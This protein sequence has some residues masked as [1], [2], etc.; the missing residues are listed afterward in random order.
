MKSID[1][2][3]D[4][5]IGIVQYDCVPVENNIRGIRIRLNG[6]ELK[7][8]WKVTRYEHSKLGGR[9]LELT[10][11]TPSLK[12]EGFDNVASGVKI[13]RIK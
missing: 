3:G 11:D 5:R 1:S 7:A 8:G 12:R 6:Q 9:K 4:N 13:E 2:P 10:A